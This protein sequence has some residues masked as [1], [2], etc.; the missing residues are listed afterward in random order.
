MSLAILS[1]LSAPAAA[2]VTDTAA[3]SEETLF[4][5]QAMRARGLDP[6]LAEMFVHAPRFMPGT[7]PVKLLVNGSERGKVSARFDS[8]GQL[9]TDAEFFRQ[10]GLVL[11]ANHDTGADCLDLRTVWPQ[12]NVNLDPGEG[13]VALV[14][15][16]DAIASSSLTSGNWTHGGTAAVLNYD[17]QAMSS[18]NTRF[19]QI[20]SEAGFNIRDWIV[21]SR[22]SF[23]R[24]NGENTSQH[25][26]AYA[27]KTL[28]ERKQV[29]QTGQ[30][31]LSNSLFGAGQ[32]WGVQLFPE[33]ALQNGKRG[34]GLVE[35]I[36]DSQ[37]VV[38]VRQSGALIYST[39]VPA[40][41]FKL[42]GFSLLNTRTDL[43]V[44]LT[45]EDGAKRQFIVPAS[46][47]LNNGPVVQPGF[48]FGAGKLDQEGSDA[49]PVIATAATGWLLNERTTLNGGV[50]GS[51]LYRAL[52]ASLDT[53]PTASTQWSVQLTGAQDTN[54]D[55]S[56]V[57][58]NTSLSQQLTERT[59]ANVNFTQQTR[60]Y[61]EINDAVQNDPLDTSD[62][63]RN[64]YGLG[65]NWSHDMLGNFS[66]SWA[67]S[68]SF[69]GGDT[70]YLR[71]SWS[72]QI[73]KA[74]L[75]VSVDRSTGNDTN[76]NRVYANLSIPFGSRSVSSYF[77][78]SSSGARAGVRYS[79]R[80][81]RD[82]G[83]SLSS[84]RNYRNNSNT[85]G[86][87]FDSVTPYSQ[88]NGSVSQDSSAG[89]TWSGRAS[90]G[91]VAHDHGVTLSPYR[92]GDTFGIAKVGDQSGIRLETPGG[93][94]W[95]DSRGYAVIPSLASFRKSTVEVDTR[96][97]DKN[98]DIANA[99]QETEAARG[100]VS[101]VS[102][103]V[104]RTRRVLVTL[105]DAQG[106]GVQ[107]GSGVF[108][109]EGGFVTVAGE[110]G[111]T[112]IPDARPGMRYA[113]QFS[114]V[115]TCHF[116]LQ[117]PEKP[118]PDELYETAVATCS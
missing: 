63:I 101:Y 29:L 81:S 70:T 46:S 2:D 94:S 110:N 25:L 107:H 74:Y 53:Q 13:A 32:V 21:R 58:V 97:L 78:H 52:A 71:G 19:A 65:I 35:G 112:F 12:S 5:V 84:D 73:S 56:G 22:Q 117:L 37:S 34:A 100:S 98:V 55:E 50:M 114:G 1:A 10:A 7:T 61:R 4:D 118:A 93:P 87:S 76:D 102:F 111:A 113:L 75:S 15:P 68:T 14:V 72:R 49:S 79:D 57:S 20:D 91:V 116:S 6:R 92:V 106:R 40:G 109:A 54:H 95:T 17:A 18:D 36:A 3:E 115:T 11:P 90:G 67:R 59:G 23:S 27:Q 80:S 62:N 104:V 38:E 108:D 89:T 85:Y 39:M 103:D 31:S 44:T 43:D 9:C 42:D 82:R 28:T 48:S 41:P 51:S 69:N 105:K 96:S 33:A 64:Q 16:P 77:N 86:A 24:F 47:F 45:G 60:G 88:L 8:E 30:I 83:W 26:A 66:A 99:W